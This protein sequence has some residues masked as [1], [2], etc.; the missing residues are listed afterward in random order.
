MVVIDLSGQKWFGCSWISEIILLFFDLAE[1][2]VLRIMSSLFIMI[3]EGA[4]QL[5]QWTTL[6]QLLVTCGGCSS[7]EGGELRLNILARSEGA[8]INR[9]VLCLG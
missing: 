6:V 9:F 8:A 2:K 7:C 1:K 3:S 4:S 5:H